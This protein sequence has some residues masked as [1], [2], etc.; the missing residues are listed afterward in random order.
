MTLPRLLLCLVLASCTLGGAGVRVSEAP[1]GALSQ[2]VARPGWRCG[3]GRGVAGLA[4]ARVLPLAPEGLGSRALLRLRGGAYGQ[5]ARQARFESRRLV[6][7]E[8]DKPQQHREALE[9]RAKMKA[10]IVARNKLEEERDRMTEEGATE[11][12]IEEMEASMAKGIMIE[13]KETA[14]EAIEGRPRRTKK[15]MEESDEIEEV[16]SMTSDEDGEGQPFQIVGPPPTRE[17]VLANPHRYLDEI[18]HLEPLEEQV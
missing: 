1:Q 18:D 4:V 17:E 5:A 16:S 9:R 12:E 2:S 13:R 8:R 14:P 6:Q 11:E 7:M 10:A 3:V 15:E